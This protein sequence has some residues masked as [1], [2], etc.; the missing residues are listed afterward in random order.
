[1][2]NVNDRSFALAAVH[3]DFAAVHL[4]D[5]AGNVEADAGARDPGCGTG[6]VE[7]VEDPRY[8][9]GRNAD[10]PIAHRALDGAV[11]D[12]NAHLHRRNAVRIL[13]GVGEKIADDLLD[14]NAVTD[15]LDGIVRC[16]KADLDVRR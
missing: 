8:L 7:P 9:V 6:A 11:L 16:R 3:M 5:V 4:H 10:P 15:D 2:K 1:M 13:D 12:C 14:E